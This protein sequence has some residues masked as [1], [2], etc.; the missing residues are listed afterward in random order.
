MFN[1]FKAI[2]DA[3]LNNGDKQ[4]MSITTDKGEHRTY[5]YAQMFS[6]AAQFAQK[7]MEAGITKG[8]RIVIVAENS[9]EWNIAYV[10]VMEM[11]CTA[12]LVDASLPESDL[13]TLIDNSDARCV[14]TSPR[15]FAKFDTPVSKLIP[16]LDIMSMAAPF[17][18]HLDK[19]ADSVP[20]TP[21]PDS[22]VAFIIYSSGTTRTATGIMHT[23]E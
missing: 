19:I 13:R 16:V 2:V 22:D 9:P 11:E 21:D 12:V 7:L 10:A 17:A 23:H 14:F 15:V 18:G 5:T 20:A 4:A 1:I 8:D 6:L 3:N